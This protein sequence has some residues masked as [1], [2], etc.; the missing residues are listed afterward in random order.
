MLH[1]GAQRP[2]SCSAT[3]L[4]IAIGRGRAG[5]LIPLVGR[6]HITQVCTI[7]CASCG[8]KVAVQCSGRGW[9]PGGQRHLRYSGISCTG[10]G[11]HRGFS[12]GVGGSRFMAQAI[13]CQTLNTTGIG[14]R[15]FY[16]YGRTSNPPYFL[17]VRPRRTKG[18]GGAS[19]VRNTAFAHLTFMCALRMKYSP[20]CG[21]TLVKTAIAS[22]RSARAP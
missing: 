8:S 22:R 10:A 19:A 18:D 3:C 5:H 14:P 16:R 17:V 13:Q 7:R 21:N 2:P 1:A 15:L 12:R 9:L 20:L 4:V 11:L 6:R